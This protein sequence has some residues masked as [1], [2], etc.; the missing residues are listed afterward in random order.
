[1]LL[2]F[3]LAFADPVV[4]I[5]GWMADVNGVPMDG[6]RVVTFR[7]FDAAS[8]GSPLWSE[9]TTVLLTSGSFQHALGSATPIPDSVF[10][11]N[12]DRWFEAQFGTSTPSERV[13]VGWAPRARYAATAG[14]AASLG[15]VPASGWTRDDESVSWT[16]LSGVPAGFTDGVD[17]DTTYL[18]GTG[19]TLDGT[20]FAVDFPFTDGRYARL[21]SG[22][23]VAQTGS[24]AIT[25]SLAAAG[26]TSTGDITATGAARFV[27]DGSG[28]TNV[29]AATIAGQTL[30]SLDLRYAAAGASTVPTPP[31]CNGLNQA[32]GW[33]GTTWVCT[34]VS[35]NNGSSGQRQRLPGRRSLGLDLGRRAAHGA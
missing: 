32:L 5:S 15:G 29:D 19:L 4:P 35:R 16:R 3:A 25:G 23:P 11:S 30:A 12:A 28:L 8:G 20:T 18:P 14:D 26:L 1:M 17:A 13:V 6:S 22:T 7:V 2:S 34:D 21:Q 27:G 24:L 9:T 33:N 10:T 31:V